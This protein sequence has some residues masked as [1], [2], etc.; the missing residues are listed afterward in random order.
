MN[1]LP[2]PRGLALAI[3][4]SLTV[5]AVLL[6]AL[7][8]WSAGSPSGTVPLQVGLL[9]QGNGE[10]A[11]GNEVR[12]AGRGT[13]PAASPARTTPLPAAPHPLKASQPSRTM[14]AQTADR[15]LPVG[16]SAETAA[17]PAQKSASLSAQ[18][19][20]VAADT[21]HAGTAANPA[22][23]P[24]EQ[25][26]TAGGSDSGAGSGQGQGGGH[27]ITPVRDGSSRFDHPRPAYPARSRDLGE[28]GRVELK[29]RVGHDGIPLEVRVWHSSGFQRLD[30]AAQRAVER[31]LFAP[32]PDG[33]TPVEAWPS[34]KITFSLADY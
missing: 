26:S 31:W 16:K 12:P 13:M 20:T 30:R 5:H 17:A 1:R 24:G 27:A 7:R 34:V 29:V 33:D 10:K 2:V 4:F 19:Q 23:V 22:T 6:A 21:G 3:L 14:A 15:A 18:S 11:I 28:E 9:V 25:G 32:A 8:P